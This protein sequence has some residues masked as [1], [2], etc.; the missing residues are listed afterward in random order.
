MQR[1]L[2]VGQIIVSALLVVLILLQSQGGG[3]GAVFGGGGG[4]E[5]YHTRKGVEK[6]IFTG[7]IIGTVLFIIISLISLIY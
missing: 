1:A 6:I 4:G 5:T 7:T 3:S 2:A